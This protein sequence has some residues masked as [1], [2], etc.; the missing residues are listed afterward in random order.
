[1]LIGLSSYSYRWAIQK[2]SM[3]L[4]DY[5]QSAC[6]AHI[7]YVQIC[8]NFPFAEMSTA[9]LNQLR[10]TYGKNLVIETGFRGHHPDD[11]ARALCATT[12]IGAKAM[13]LVVED[14]RERSIDME[15]V[16]A[17]L[18]TILP[19][20]EQHDLQLCL[21]N[22][23]LLSPTQI[24]ELIQRLP[25]QRIS[26]C[27]DCFNSIALNIA[28]NEALEVLFPYVHRIHIK[29]VCIERIGTGFCF[30]GCQLGTGILNL[31]TLFSRFVQA[32]RQPLLFLEGWI[33][34]KKTD[35]ETIEYEDLVNKQGIAYLRS[36]FH[37]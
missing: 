25:S 36:Y 30:K 18:T 15:Q 27:F 6:D 1:M 34:K 5:L 21:E 33:D 28:T 29:D 35:Q 8:E 3:N 16:V 13:R 17:D 26:V 10:D 9:E 37:E 24:V 20:L 2:G 19:L 7:R 12:A 22:H 4:S 31:D 32:G 14:I 23:F 11:L